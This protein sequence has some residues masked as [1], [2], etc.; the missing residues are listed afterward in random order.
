MTQPIVS[1]TEYAN[2]LSIALQEIDN[3]KVESFYD[4]I[5]YA[6]KDNKRIYVIGNGGSAA[7]ASHFQGDFVK[8]VAEDSNLVPQVMSLVDNSPIVTALAN[9]ISYDKV[10]SKQIE[11]YGNDDDL[12]IAISSSGNSLNIVNAVKEA[13]YKNMKVVSISGF[14]GGE[15][16]KLSHLSIVINSDNYGI[17][18]DATSAILHYINQSFRCDFSKGKPEDIK[19]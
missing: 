18:E 13:K 12:L 15:I 2:K 19:Y 5:Y 6:I 9:D 1:L 10:F 4:M 14:G 17:V 7:I 8:C 16:S 11:W 3:D